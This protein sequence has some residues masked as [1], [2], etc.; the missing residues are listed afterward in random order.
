MY[1]LVSLFPSP[2]IKCAK[3]RKSFGELARSTLHSID[4]WHFK[5]ANF[6]FRASMS[7]QKL[8]NV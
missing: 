1:S 8:A 5:L 3:E 7:A 2:F 4:L 6:I